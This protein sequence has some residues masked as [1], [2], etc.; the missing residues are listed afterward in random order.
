[1]GACD[2][3]C[4]ENLMGEL[5][6]ERKEYIK[7]TNSQTAEKNIL[8]KN[9]DCNNC[10]KQTVCKYIDINVSEVISAVDNTLSNCSYNH[11]KVLYFVANCKEYKEKTDN[12]KGIK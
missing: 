5:Y 11:D 12:I 8:I 9:F 3:D 10:I 7:N 1:M 4:Y 2:C 6:G